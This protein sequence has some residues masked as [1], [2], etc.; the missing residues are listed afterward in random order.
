V[1]PTTGERLGPAIHEKTTG[2]DGYWGPFTAK[3]DAYYEFV[4][5]APGYAVTHVYWP[6]FPRSSA[7]LHFEPGSLSKEDRR[8]GS[9]I[10]LYRNNGELAHGHGKTSI[11]GAPAPGLEDGVPGMRMTTQRLPNSAPRAVPV[12]LNGEHLT[13]RSWPVGDNNLVIA[14]FHY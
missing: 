11:D 6:P 9:V 5:T 12:V 3:S 14:S 8:A 13:V 1:S 4:I 2:T 7:F 10:A